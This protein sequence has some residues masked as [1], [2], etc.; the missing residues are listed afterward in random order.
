VIVAYSLAAFLMSCS[1]LLMATKQWAA[2]FFAVALFA[3]GTCA[4]MAILLTA[5][6]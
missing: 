3:T 5:V 1:G 2:E 4:V 6:S